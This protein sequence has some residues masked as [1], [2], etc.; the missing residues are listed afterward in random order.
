MSC[1]NLDKLSSNSVKSPVSGEHVELGS[2]WRDQTVVM[3]FLRRFGCQICRWT[4]VEVSKLEKDLR[5]NGV[6]L[7]GIGPEETGLQEFQDGGFFKGEIYI[8]EKK[9]CYKDLGFKRYNAINVLPAALG[10]KVRDIASKASSEGIQGNFSGDVLQSGGML[11]VAKG[12]EKV[13]LHFIQETPGDF[14]PLEDISKALD[15]RVSVQAG[16]RPQ[17]DD[18]VCT[19]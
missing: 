8:D 9:Q 18:D 15:I 4:A 12:G 3:F 1:V 14:V 5:A 10:K 7:V 19:R 13:L 11:I 6:A 16:V 2:L 17:C